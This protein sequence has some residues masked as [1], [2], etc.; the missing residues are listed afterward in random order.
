MYKVMA[1]LRSVFLVF[2]VAYAVRGL[3]VFAQL[4][5]TFDEQYAR[6]RESVST[7]QS[8]VWYAVGWIALE[9]A[10]GWFLATRKS[11]QSAPPPTPQA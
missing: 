5:R 10:I 2:I 7:L 1:V 8:A 3:P 9:A 6:C 4:A 11:R